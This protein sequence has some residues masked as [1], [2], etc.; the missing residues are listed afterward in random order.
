MKNLA[1]LVLLISSNAFAF[2][3]DNSQNATSDATAKASANVRNANINGNLN[4]NSNSLS[5]KNYN[6]NIQGQGQKQGQAQHQSNKSYNKN[7]STAVQGQALVDNG[8]VNISSNTQ[9]DA[10]P[11]YAP[12]Q[13]L[14]VSNQTCLAGIGASLGVGGIFSG[15]FAGVHE[16][17]QCTFRANLNHITALYGRDVA[18]AYAEKYLTGLAGV[19][20]HDDEEEDD[21][22]IEASNQAMI[23]QSVSFNG[24]I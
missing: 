10:E 12:S 23:N 7:D 21:E 18:K 5:N 6:A 11:A 14:D 13:S 24:R 4:K 8:S 22:L 9:V 1:F 15:G 20:N 16:D 2:G 17:E 19:L 3:L